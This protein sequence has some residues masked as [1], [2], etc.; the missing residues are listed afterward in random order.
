M[1]RTMIHCYTTIAKHDPG[2][3]INVSCKQKSL[4]RCYTGIQ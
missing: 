2:T 1:Y 4:V 3:M